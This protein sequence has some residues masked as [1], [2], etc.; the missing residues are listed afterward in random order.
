MTGTCPVCS[1]D[2]GPTEDPRGCF[3]CLG[4]RLWNSQDRIVAVLERARGP[5]AYWDVKRLLER[6]DRKPVNTR[7]LVSSLAA[8][9]RTCW[10]GPG[11]YGLYRHGLLPTVRDM[12]CVAAVFI[13]AADVPMSQEQARF[14]LRFVGYRFRSTSINQALRRVEGAGLLKRRWGLWLPTS[15]SMRPL[16]RL[17]R[18]D[19]VKA[20]MNRA[21]DQAGNALEAWDERREG[22]HEWLHPVPAPDPC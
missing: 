16:L 13:H 3:T 1:A 17:W 14:L 9:T 19:D 2:L 10:G 15:R 6:E 18:S 20:V 12:G 8:D 22:S 4:R 11:I 21:A 5:L 7:S